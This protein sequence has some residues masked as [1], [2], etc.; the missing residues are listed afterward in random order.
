MYY[1][2]RPVFVFDGGVPPLKR[3]TIVRILFSLIDSNWTIQ[4][5]LFHFSSRQAKRNRN[6]NKYQNEADKLQ[7]LLLEALAKEKVVQ[8][9]LG[10]ST[11]ALLSGSPPKKAIK[12][13]EDE[14]ND[15]FKLPPVQED[16]PKDDSY[17]DVGES[18]ES[19]DEKQRTI[20]NHNLQAIDVKS[21]HFLSLP[22][23]I[24]HEILTDIKGT[25]KQSSWGRLHELPVESQSFSSFQMSRLLKRR[26][27]QVE[28]EE[29][30]KEMGGK[31]LSMAELENLLSEEGVVDPDLATERIASSDHIRYLHVRDITKA[32]KKES[33]EKVKK[34]KLDEIKEEPEAEECEKKSK[35]EIVESIK[36]EE[37][38]DEDFDLQRAIQMSLGAPDPLEANG[39]SDTV[40]LTVE[41]KKALGSAANSLAR[42]YMIE[43]GGMNDEDV[44][45][46]VKIDENVNTTQEFK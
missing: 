11:S 13:T 26:Q 36:A 18:D 10:A 16:L 20:Y 8:Q 38:N 28:L 4:A 39:E 29:A 42:H 41:Q 15:L 12:N 21:S 45:D 35:I 33:E 2:I 46:L 30:E 14:D 37:L 44:H 9:A 25:R 31:G 17:T 24:R 5:I 43:Y 3:E 34:E 23:D 6:K 1:R 40:R 32:L 22:A 27:V 7:H 19:F